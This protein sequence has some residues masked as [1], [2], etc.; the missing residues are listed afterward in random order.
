MSLA[1][2]WDL[3][4]D[5]ELVPCG[6]PAAASARR[7]VRPEAVWANAKPRAGCQVTER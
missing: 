7:K 5:T 4:V 3:L 1:T 2:R 6:W